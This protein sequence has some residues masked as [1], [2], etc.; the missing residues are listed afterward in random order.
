MYAS[1]FFLPAELL[2]CEYQSFQSDGKFHITAAHHILN[3][4][5]QKFC[6]KTQFLN[7]SCILPCCQSGLLLTEVRKGY[8]YYCL[9]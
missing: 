2:V 6:R 5:I 1:F 4:K 7:N 9:N 3:F 8:L